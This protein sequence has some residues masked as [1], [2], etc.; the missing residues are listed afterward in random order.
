MKLCGDSQVV[1]HLASGQKYR[2]FDSF[3][4]LHIEANILEVVTA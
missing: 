1:W 3:S 2:R 4:P